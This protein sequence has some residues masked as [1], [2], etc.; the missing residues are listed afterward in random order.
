MKR[1]KPLLRE[2]M[3]ELAG[4]LESLLRKNEEA[5]LARQVAGLRI[6]DRCRCGDDFCATIYAAPKPRAAWGAGHETIALDPDEGYMNVDLLNGNIV[7]VE[8]LFR[9]E[10]RD[11]L[12]KLLP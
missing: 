9:D 6:I 5:E 7:E 10:I 2:A 12:L 11:Q 3:P 1:A 8:V 4:E